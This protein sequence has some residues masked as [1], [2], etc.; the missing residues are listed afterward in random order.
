MAQISQNIAWHI[1]DGHKPSTSRFRQLL[2]CS[3]CREHFSSFEKTAMK[4][5]MPVWSYDEIELLRKK[6][7]NDQLDSI[8]VKQLFDIWGGLPRYVLHKASSN[9]FVFFSFF[10]I[11]YLTNWC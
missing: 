7:F 9:I 10:D 2:I 11:L 8:L 5:Y 6:F 4:Y 1:V 3:P